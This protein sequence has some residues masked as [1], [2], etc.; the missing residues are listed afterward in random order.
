MTS[1][2]ITIKQWPPKHSVTIPFWLKQ[3]KSQSI[4]Q[5]LQEQQPSHSH[6]SLRNAGR[7]FFSAMVEWIDG[8]R[9]MQTQHHFTG[10][11]T[12]RLHA[13]LLFTSVF[14]VCLLFVYY[15]YFRFICLTSI[16]WKY[17]D[18]LSISTFPFI[19]GT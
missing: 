7:G 16:C 3:N 18:I 13:A 9:F 11:S 5:W 10:G 2:T 14:Y 6:I 15:F 17:S 1:A 12:Q 8:G 4:K 19:I